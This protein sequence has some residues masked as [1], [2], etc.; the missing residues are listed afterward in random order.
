MSDRTNRSSD[1]HDKAVDI[2]L[3]SRITNKMSAAV[4]LHEVLAHV[5]AF[6]TSLIESDSCILY[7]MENEK[8]VLRA[9]K[10]P[11]PEVIDRLSVR[12]GQG[13]T[14][15]VAEHREPVVIGQ[16]AY[17]DPRF[18]TFSELPEDRFEAF[19]S[20]PVVCGGRLVG[21]I[22]V[23]NRS[24]HNFSEREIGLVATV[25]LLVG[26]EIERVR[27]EAENVRLSDKLE[28]RKVIERAKGVL[29][30]DLNLSEEDAYRLL[31]RESQ[32]R[33]RSMKHIAEAIILGND[34]NR[35]K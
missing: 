20:V 17:D 1:P 7:V 4:P 9:S 19:L 12:I 25:G 11:H 26:A 24:P 6:V 28:E 22:N 32:D 31:Q 35:S 30:R 27:L 21:V 33:R 34:M 13:I 3:L 29:Q 5:I 16:R 10:N 14:G 8:L 18:E 15:W 2:T 23:Q